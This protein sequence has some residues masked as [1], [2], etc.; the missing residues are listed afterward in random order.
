MNL[1]RPIFLRLRRRV[2]RSLAM[3]PFSFIG[4]KWSPPRVPDPPSPPQRSRN[5]ALFALLGLGV[6]LAIFYF[7]G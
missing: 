7:R 5:G 3:S 6:I 2:R 1:P 4:Q